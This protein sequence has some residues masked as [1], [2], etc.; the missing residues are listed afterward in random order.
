MY[1]RHI[2]RNAK[3]HVFMKQ[4]FFIPVYPAKVQLLS[5]EEA[6]MVPMTENR[7]TFALG[8]QGEAELQQNRC[9]FAG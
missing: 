9:T 5:S 1:P 8:V 6:Q 4:T 3:V 2:F 7:C